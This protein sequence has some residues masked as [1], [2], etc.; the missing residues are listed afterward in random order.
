[1][2]HKRAL[3]AGIIGQ[4]GSYLAKFLLAKGYEVRRI[5]RVT[6][7]IEHILERLNPHCADMTDSISLLNTLQKVRP[8]EVYNL[9]A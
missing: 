6:R 4:D 3:I 7:Y 5:N 1:M 2:H 9:T 8:Q